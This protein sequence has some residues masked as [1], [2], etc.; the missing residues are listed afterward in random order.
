MITIEP[1]TA[2]QK[3]ID[4]EADPEAARRSQAVSIS[5]SALI[6]S[7]NSPIV[8]MMN[9]IEKNVT[10]GFTKALTTPRI[11]ATSSSGPSLW[12]ISAEPDDGPV[13]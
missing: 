11:S 12:W 1:R 4:V 5:I 3:P 8:R 10:T 9:G 7:R 13:K 2:F 6:T